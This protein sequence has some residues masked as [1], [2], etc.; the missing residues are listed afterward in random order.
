MASA[1]ANCI[2]FNQVMI[3]LQNM[4]GVCVVSFLVDD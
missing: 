2:F 3:A 4:G 1:D